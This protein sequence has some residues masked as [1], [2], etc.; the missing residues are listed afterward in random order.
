M[1]MAIIN[2]KLYLEIFKFEIN[3]CILL[4]YILKHS[5]NKIF[6]KNDYKY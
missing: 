4:I 6:V 3:F 2:Q 1:I 5:Y